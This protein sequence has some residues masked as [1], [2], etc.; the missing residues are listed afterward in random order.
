MRSPHS[1]LQIEQTQVL[2]PVFIGEVLQSSNHLH[3][4][5]LN[6]LQKLSVFPVL[7]VPDLDAVLQMG[8]HKGRVERDNH[9]LLPA[10][11]PSSNAAWDTIGLPGCKSTESNLEIRMWWGTTSRALRKAR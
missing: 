4:P 10:G 6:P 3:G 2:K 1:L 9:L 11:H 5:S 7:E 8:T